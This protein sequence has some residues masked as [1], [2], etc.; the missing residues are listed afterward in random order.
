MFR[1]CI[2]FAVIV[3]VGATIPLAASPANA[4]VHEIVGQWC[5]GK[6]PLAPPGIS[7][8]SK[9]N[10]FAAPLFANDVVSIHPYTG[11][12]GPGLLIDFDFDHPAAKISPT[13]GII[14]AGSTPDGPLYLE[15]FIPDPDFA[16]F[17]HCPNL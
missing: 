16:A 8:G 17:R 3:V 4:T 9:A 6:D 2:R 14:V 1:I 12:A 7:G 15:A 10:N 13:G 5:S 11:S